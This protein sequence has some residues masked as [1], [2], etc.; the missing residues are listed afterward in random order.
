MRALSAGAGIHVAIG[1]LTWAVA[2]A[3]T[4][5][6][7]SGAGLTPEF[8]AITSVACG[9]A[10]LFWV[11]LIAAAW[12]R[13][14]PPYVPG[15]LHEGAGT[16][17]LLA[18]FAG[19]GVGAHAGLLREA[20]FSGSDHPAAMV[21]YFGLLPTALLV[22]V[23]RR[24]LWR[25]FAEIATTM[26]GVEV[27][28]QLTLS[29]IKWKRLHWWG[30]IT[31]MDAAYLGVGCAATLLWWTYQKLSPGSGRRPRIW[32]TRDDDDAPPPSKA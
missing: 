16:A 20:T 4:I 5:L 21:V 32:H 22:S 19:T 29:W 14:R 7:L 24:P 28:A 27:A 23:P 11:A 9:V 17:L 6:Q 1:T 12:V 10:T 13:R 2:V 3:V 25:A 18:L 15:A 30:D 8:Q 26:A 31:G